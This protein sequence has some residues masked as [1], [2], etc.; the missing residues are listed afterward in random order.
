MRQSRIVENAEAFSVSVV[1]PAYNSGDTIQRAVRSVLEQSYPP[2]E[3]L[4]IDDASSDDTAEKVSAIRDDRIRLLRHA[5]NLNGAVARNTGIDAASG[6]WIALLD[7][8]DAWLP[9]KLERQKAAV[10]ARKDHDTA[11]SFGQVQVVEPHRTVIA[12]S[13]PPDPSRTLSEYALL[14]RGSV[15]T[16]TQ[17][18]PAALA[19]KVRFDP[20]MRSFQ[21]LDFAFRMEAAGARYE[22]VEDVLSKMFVEPGNPS[23][24]SQSAPF[25]HLEAWL[26]RNRHLSIREQASMLGNRIAPRALRSGQRGTA[27]L[28]LVPG[29]VTGVVPLKSSISFLGQIMLPLDTYRSARGR[30]RQYVYGSQAHELPRDRSRQ[31]AYGRHGAMPLDSGSSWMDL[32]RVAKKALYTATK[33]PPV[34]RGLRRGYEALPG[35]PVLSSLI[36]KLTPEPYAY[37]LN[38]SRELSFGDET[39]RLRPAHQIQWLQFFGRPDPVLSALVDTVEPGD[40]VIDVAA[41]VGVYA[42]RLAERVGPAGRIAALE[43]S[44][45]MYQDL[46]RHAETNAPGQIKTLQVALGNPARRSVCPPSTNDRVATPSGDAC[47]PGSAG[48]EIDARR[49]D[50]VFP[51]LG[52]SRL[53][54][55]RIDKEGFEQE[56]LAGAMATVEAYAPSLQLTV[57]PP[58]WSEEPGAGRALLE[59]LGELPY[60]WFAIEASHVQPFD[61]CVWTKTVTPADRPR[62][63]LARPRR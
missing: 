5:K 28:Y 55:L 21:E 61:L 48:Q 20:R 38:E 19:K 63:L 42:V 15:P 22:M 46:L 27:L 26:K 29:L 37:G 32:K 18:F 50:D 34:E 1:I 36:D 25:A 11:C 54:L 17:L 53:D 51:T 58:A 59:R 39:W 2:Q 35:V 43:A 6:Q 56:I 14:E 44:P 62:N 57:Y 52:W 4:V 40:H 41:N 30:Y 45:Q 10:L 60:E 16:S 8:D 7:A 13:S 9:N 24:V 49:L 23:H 47:A 33:R 3:I 31:T 12:P